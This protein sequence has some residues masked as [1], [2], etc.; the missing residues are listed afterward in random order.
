MSLKLTL[1][2]TGTSTGVPVIGCSCKTCTSND[3]RDKRGRVSAM[4]EYEDESGDAYRV[5]I[6]TPPD[7]RT[8]MLRHGVD[9]LDAVLFTHFHMDHIGG[10]DD[11]RRFNIVMEGPVYIYVEQ[12]TMDVLGRVYEYVFDPRKNKV[13]TFIAQI[14]PNL[15]DLESKL[16]FGDREWTPIRLMHGRLPIL[17]FRVGRMA[18]CT[19]VSSIPPE[20]Y[21]LL[22]DLDVLVIDGLRYRHHPTHF[23]IDQAL[24]AIADI[25]PERAYLTHIAHEVL[26][27][28]L[29]SR[30][31][32]NVHL[33]YDGL[34]LDVSE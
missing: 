21:P 27:A 16:T 28:D 32:P 14:V 2:G 11:L 12:A 1:L 31:P 9:R 25:R 6:D 29:E 24:E 4:V 30:L 33:A 7:M 19:D 3:P 26:H 34:Q 8:Q 22:R 13:Q 20:S 18:Y 17:G 23:N 15:I 5:L 10:F